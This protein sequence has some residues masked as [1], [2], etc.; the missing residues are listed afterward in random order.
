MTS[1]SL[2]SS[3]IHRSPQRLH[4]EVNITRREYEVLHLIAFEYSTKEVANKLY[5]S[6]ETANT[7]RQNLMKKL[8]VRNT[9]GLI[10]VAFEVGLLVPEK[11]KVS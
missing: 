9:A 7:H 3:T 10:R 8:D 1:T 4:A 5:V 2:L 11:Q 6:Y